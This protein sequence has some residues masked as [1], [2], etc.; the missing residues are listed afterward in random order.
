MQITGYSN[1]NAGNK[2]K[3]LYPDAILWY[4]KSICDHSLN[5]VWDLVTC[6]PPVS[7]L[8]FPLCLHSKKSIDHCYY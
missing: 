3:V 5:P 6:H 7:L 2:I 4:T 8:M 1:L